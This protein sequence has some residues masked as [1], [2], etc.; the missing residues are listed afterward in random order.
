MKKF[1]YILIFALALV[2]CAQRPAVPKK[3]NGYPVSV[4]STNSRG[5]NSGRPPLPN[6]NPIKTKM[7]QELHDITGS[8]TLTPSEIFERLSSA[9]FKIHTSTGYQGFQ[10]SGF[11]ISSNGVA[12][13]NYH[14]FQGTAI[15]YEDIILS[16]G[17]MYKVKEVYYKSQKNDFIIFKVGVE[18][19]VNFI[20]I[21]NATP[22]VGE[23][24]YTIGSPRGLDNTFSS[25]EISQLRDNGKI[26]QISAPIDHGSSGG[27]LLNTKGEAVGITSGGI[28]DSGANLNYAWN[29]NLI[30]PYIP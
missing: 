21:S 13:S 6:Q 10:G 26:L 2:S 18:K 28:D 29:I 3:G 1:I 8:R 17:S 9:V 30:K 12:V 5:Y 24:I 25:G 23:K 14:V 16:D 19:K 20:K 7:G 4:P 22:K 11:F 15:G 27:V